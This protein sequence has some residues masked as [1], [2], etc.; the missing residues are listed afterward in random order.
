MVYTTLFFDLDD[1]LYPN[2]SGLWPAIK[3]RMSQFMYERLGLPWEEIPALRRK[4]YETY[5]TTLRGLQTHYGVNADDYLAYVHDLPLEKFIHPDP[6]I[7]NLLLS[8]PQ[9]KWIFT[10]A[11]FYHAHRVLSRLNLLDCFKGIVDVR[12]VLFAC[13]PEREAFERALELSGR[14]DP[15]NCVFLDDSAHN[16]S[17]AVELGFFTILVGTGNPDPSASLSIKSLLDLPMAMPELWDG[18][19]GSK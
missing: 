13:K 5:G 11:D 7:R 6:E 14:P 15:K 16:L 10:N 12:A 19:D 2:T 1:T 3:D 4:Y 17:G 18:K 9:P 8:L